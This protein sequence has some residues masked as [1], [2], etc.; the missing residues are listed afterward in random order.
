MAVLPSG[1]ERIAEVVDRGYHLSG[2]EETGKLGDL[3]KLTDLQ[4]NQDE[5]L[6]LLLQSLFLSTSIS[7][8]PYCLLFYRPVAFLHPDN[9]HMDES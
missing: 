7:S 3:D 9:I 2:L 6:E 1:G 8:L 4:W 5:S